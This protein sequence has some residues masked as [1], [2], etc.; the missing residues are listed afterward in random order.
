MFDSLIA[1]SILRHVF[2]ASLIELIANSI[3]YLI[4]LGFLVFVFLYL[5]GRKYEVNKELVCLE[6]L[7]PSNIARSTEASKEFY[8]VVSELKNA[9]LFNTARLSL[10]LVSEAKAGIRYIIY[11][12]KHDAEHIKRQLRSFLPSIKIKQ[13]EDYLP[14]IKDRPYSATFAFKLKDFYAKPLKTDLKP[15]EHDPLAYVIGSMT[16][17][18]PNELVAFQLV[19]SKYSGR[20]RAKDLNKL[21]NRP[22]HN[23]ASYVLPFWLIAKLA[24]SIKSVFS[25]NNFSD[26]HMEAMKAKLSGD[27]FS[28]SIRAIVAADNKKDLQERS[29][30]LASSL[31]VY[32]SD[33]S[34]ALI[35]KRTLAVSYLKNYL[36]KLYE[37]RLPS[38]LPGQNSILSA[39][40]LTGLYHF[41]ETTLVSH[42]ALNRSNSRQLPIALGLKHNKSDVI[43][44]NNIY[45]GLTNPISLSEEER[46]K[47]LLILG[48]TGNGKTSMLKHAIIQ[49]INSGKGLAIIDPHGDLAESLLDFIPKSRHKD[50]IYFDPSDIAHPIGLNILEIDK[51]LSGD[52]LL[53]FKDLLCE[54]VISIFRK[55]FSG[56]DNGGNRLEYILRN[57]IETAFYIDDATIFH[58][59]RLLVDSAYR[60]EIVP[61]LSDPSLRSF[62][63]NE[64]NQAG[65][66]QRVKLS[67]GITSKIGR[68]LRTTVTRRVL[69]QAKSTIDFDDIINSSKILICNFSKGKIGEDSSSLLG[70]S[71]L[72]K[73]QIA[74]YKRANIKNNQRKAFHIYIDEFQNYATSS[75]TQLISEG[76]KY[77]VYLSMAE[78][79]PSQQIDKR[80]FSVLLANVGTIVCFRLTSPADEKLLLPLFAPTVMAGEM[81][82]LPSYSYYVRVGAIKVYEPC[83]GVTII[84][85]AK[86]SNSKIDVIKLSRKQYSLIK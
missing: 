85:K 12:K 21:N 8:L 78:Q 41:P 22:V 75:L 18:A 49:D 11:A 35:L 19:I 53:L 38:L 57:A 39:E 84:D 16:K 24:G 10:E 71:V 64:F 23:K 15:S 70:M 44:G 30:A 86:A 14:S 83:S 58:V 80:Q 9:G 55:L 20:A 27:L 31:S 69:G 62:W 50:V 63:L 65:N 33:V 26:Q 47:H 36:Y 76:R 28:V 60:K 67:I 2:G 32:N 59:Y 79:S 6:V 74:A 45:H 37:S 40:E 81:F 61:K 82:N 72:A 13:V 4:I 29:I 48:G 52:D 25:S 77:G 43:L 68:F 7:A 73:L 1:T 34:Q 3:I 5:R 42:E 54:Q 46:R 56:E 66:M 51:S 17:L